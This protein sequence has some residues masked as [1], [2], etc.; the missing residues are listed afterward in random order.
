MNIYSDTRFSGI[1]NTYVVDSNGYVYIYTSQLITPDLSINTDI[2]IRIVNHGQKSGAYNI[3]DVASTCSKKMIDSTKIMHPELRI[4]WELGNLNKI[5][6][7]KNCKL[8][9]FIVAVKPF[10]LFTL[11]EDKRHLIN[12]L[13]WNLKPPILMIWLLLTKLVILC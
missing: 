13:I 1:A 2:T 10:L 7:G 6:F 4:T 12:Q 3:L 9:F 11:L 8:K 5:V